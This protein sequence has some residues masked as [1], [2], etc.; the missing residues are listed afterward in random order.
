MAIIIEKWADGKR[1]LS[2]GPLFREYTVCHVQYSMATAVIHI[3]AY[4]MVIISRFQ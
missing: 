3:G 1:Q 4:A 2:A